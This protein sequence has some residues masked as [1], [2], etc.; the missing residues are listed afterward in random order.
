MAAAPGTTDAQGMAKENK[1]QEMDN[2][3]ELLHFS[4]S[5]SR[6]VWFRPILVSS[7]AFKFKYGVPIN[8]RIRQALEPMTITS[9]TNIY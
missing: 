3:Y 6:L 4:A 7:E 8:T 2:D 5:T 9:I 1:L